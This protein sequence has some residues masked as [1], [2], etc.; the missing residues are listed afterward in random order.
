[1]ITKTT[2][3]MKILKILPIAFLITL[4]S[5]QWCAAQE[6][7]KDTTAAKKADTTDVDSTKP[8]IIIMPG[9]E[10]PRLKIGVRTGVN[11]SN[12]RYSHE[13]INR[14]AHQIRNTGMLGIFA[15]MPLDK[16]QF[17]LR[18]EL[19]LISR[20]TNLSW[21]D[22]K[23]DFTAHYVDLRLPLTYNFKL[24]NEHISPYLM[25]AP[26]LNRPYGGIITY[27]AD[28]YNPAVSAPITK[29]DIKR[30]DVSCM[31]GGG[32]DFR[33]DFER[34]PLYVSVEAG[35]NFGFINNFAKRE[36]FDA[37][38][39]PSI[40]LNN[41][42]GAELW[43]GKRHTRGI[44]IALRVAFPLDREFVK[45][46]RENRLHTPDTVVQ[47]MTD[48]VT[49]PTDTVVVQEYIPEK[50]SVKTGY[51]TK[52][53]FTI[54][55][56]YN[57]MEQGI[58]ITGKRI[59]MFDIK[60]DFDSYKIRPESEKPLNELTQMMLEYPQM[61]VE[62]YGHTDSIG[63]VDYNQRLSENR[64]KAVKEYITNHGISPARIKSFGYGLK[65]PIDDN[66]TE[67]GRFHNRRV[68][69]E[70]ITIGESRKYRK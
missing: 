26:M 30:W 6:V 24:K 42:F 17:S 53:C 4:L 10:R 55:E 23:Y 20:G 1:M 32:V 45:R 51:Q 8:E 19:T 57:L 56:L 13:P 15:E 46:Y 59:C 33:V 58:N 44:E 5:A 29:A 38:D 2:R 69:F 67:Q 70:V 54:A 47:I 60:F 34:L 11:F 61:T 31:L 39:N 37:T 68:E 9:V 43:K 3:E 21:K 62:V 27:S 22:V 48:T 41:F 64:A 49:G 12:F 14:Y 35:Y 7:V 52:E 50:R 40:I 36:Q 16:S 25:V 63:P 65:Y 28:D 66:S 18:P